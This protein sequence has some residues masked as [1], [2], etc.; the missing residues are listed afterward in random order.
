V[1][2]PFVGRSAELAALDT[3]YGRATAGQGQ[4]VLIVGPPGIGKTVLTRKFVSSRRAQSVAASGDPDETALA[5]GLLEQ[6][7]GATAVPQAQ[8]LREAL[9]GSTADPLGPGSLLLDLVHELSADQPLVVVI[10]DA[11]WGDELSL[12]ALSFA[13]RR[14]RSDAV[15]CLVLTRSEELTRL[16]SGL[17]RLVAD[18]GSRLNLAGVAHHDVAELAELVGVGR[19]SG[20]AALRLHEHTGGVPLHVMELLHDLPRSV[21]QAPG[22]GL[23]APRSLET[24]V[25]SRLAGCAPETERLVVAAAVL[26]AE[27]RLGDAAA[28][29][30]LDDPLPALQEAVDHRLLRELDVIDGRCCA[31]PHAMLRAAVYQDI[32]IDR[33]ATLHRA[34]ASLCTGP[35]ALAHR[36][37]G[38]RGADPELAADLD[39][40][41]RAEL[42]AGR[43]AEAVEHL[44]TSVRVDV[45]CSDRDSRL[46]TAAGML[47]DLGDVARARGYADEIDAMPPSGQRS[48]LLGRLSVLTGDYRGA[49]Q[50]LTEAWAAPVPTARPADG[51]AVAACEL[52][53]ML[54]RHHRTGDA[55]I[56]AER[57]AGAAA[58]AFTRACSQVVLG[59]CLAMAGQ[60][61]QA[62][63]LLEGQLQGGTPEPGAMLT[64]AGLGTVLLWT[65]D[66]DGA[67]AHLGAA[68]AAVGTSGLPLSH[69]L[70]ACLLKVQTDYRSGQWDE[71]ACGAERLLALADD[72]D[73][74]WML[75]RAHAAAVYPHAARGEWDRAA[76][77]VGAAEQHAIDGQGSGL[78]DLVNARAALAFAR[79]DAAAVITAVG[80][81][82][83]GLATLAG[84]E[85]G[86]LGFWPAYAR[87]LVRSGQ[88]DTADQVLRPFELLARQRGRRS[89]LAAAGRVRGYLEATRRQPDAA[90]CAFDASLASLTGL[91]MP[92][93]EGLTR[94][95]YGRFLR[96]QGERRAAVRQLSAARSAFARLG[97]R[98]FADQCDAEL[99]ERTLAAD[100]ATAAGMPVTPLTARQLTVA[101]A[102]ATGK[103][104]REVARE[105]YISVKTVEFHV[106]QILTRLGVDSRGEIEKALLRESV[107][108]GGLAGGLQGARHS[109]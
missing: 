101:R 62:R 52:A 36:V 39:A 42:A 17:L 15:L 2:E 83:G 18:L 76:A 27:C 33:R 20:R 29:A 51:A 13:L 95:E 57:A 22:G 24:L 50:R 98:P 49:E 72:L 58:T 99:G 31:F 90:R 63:A 37:A 19:L 69:L 3:R 85:P 44:L 102:I 48:L 100:P 97:A 103:S 59:L 109:G 30:G 38:R 64:R 6:L 96:R 43:P 46:L 77:H 106:G 68:A 34:A 21:L 80:P 5:G 86:L 93:E 79:D 82:S 55:T 25:L 8:A 40:K 71:A 7:A 14:L 91:G 9:T 53:L 41:A 56:W 84:L 70:E 28:L 60:T 66:L 23:P 11:H 32:G 65:D 81:I 67:S 89:A 10:D 105:L 16:P 54:M 61:D 4:V 1:E 35:A 75:L 88:A 12:R 73:Q 26:G 92:F 45:R 108:G 107:A 78:I 94:L 47:I 87:A 74:G 104:N